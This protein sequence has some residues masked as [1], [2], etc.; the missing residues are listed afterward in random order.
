MLNAYYVPGYTV[1]NWVLRI[2]LMGRRRSRSK[3]LESEGFCPVV[4]QEKHVP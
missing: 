4:F 1:L 2:G 3:D